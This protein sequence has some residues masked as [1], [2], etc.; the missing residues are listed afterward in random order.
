MATNSNLSLLTLP[1][2]IRLMI[3]RTYFHSL[4]MFVPVKQEDNKFDISTHVLFFRDKMT[5]HT[6][7][8]VGH[9][10]CLLPLHT[11]CKQIAIETEGMLQRE[12]YFI[13]DFKAYGA[14]F[15]FPSQLRSLESFDDDDDD[16]DEK[17]DDAIMRDML[18]SLEM[19]LFR[20]CSSG[21]DQ[22]GKRDGDGD[23]DG[24]GHEVGN[25]T[26][27]PIRR[28]SICVDYGDW[29]PEMLVFPLYRNRRLDRVADEDG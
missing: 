3:F 25:K 6:Q 22:N 21:G 11:V 1:V 9:T 15:R 18:D 12:T 4:T 14:R 10:F 2:E 13:F 19:R 28:G 26:L 29:G 5:Y 17:Y 20:G 7:Y 27:E 23:E 16:K 8:A 24:N